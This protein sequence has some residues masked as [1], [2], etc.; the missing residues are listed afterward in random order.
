MIIERKRD[1]KRGRGREGEVAVDGQWPLVILSRARRS[2]T[3]RQMSRS[4]GSQS[5]LHSY[6]IA[7]RREPLLN[8]IDILRV[9]MQRAAAV[10]PNRDARHARNTPFA[11]GLRQQRRRETPVSPRLTRVPHARFAQQ[12]CIHSVLNP[13]FSLAEYISPS[14]DDYVDLSVSRPRLA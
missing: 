13:A 2:L 3:S 6:L 11:A 1:R 4:R 8:F 5:A 9:H 14:R 10:R 12:S 7:T